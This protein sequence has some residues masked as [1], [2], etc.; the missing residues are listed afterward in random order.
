MRDWEYAAK[1]EPGQKWARGFYPYVI[2]GKRVY[3]T[4]YPEVQ[5]VL[6]S[7]SADTVYVRAMRWCNVPHKPSGWH[8]PGN[9]YVCI[10]TMSNSFVGEVFEYQLKTLGYKV[11]DRARMAVCKPPDSGNEYTAFLLPTAKVKQ[12]TQDNLILHSSDSISLVQSKDTRENVLT[13]R[14]G[15]PY[16]EL[17]GVLRLNP[18]GNR[19]E[20]VARGLYVGRTRPSEHEGL[21]ESLRLRRRD[22]DRMT[23]NDVLV[24]VVLDSYNSKPHARAF[25]EQRKLEQY[26]IGYG[27]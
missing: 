9:E 17:T 19:Y 22:S 13:L 24:T 5:A 7:I 1:L 27:H 11:G 15:K 16:V 2:G 23:P 4:Q 20:C 18:K 25:L 14:N 10:V 12:A 26:R 6:K 8:D 21:V 3:G